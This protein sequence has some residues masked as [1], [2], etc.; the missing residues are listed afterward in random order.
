VAELGRV[1]VVAPWY[2][3]AGRPYWGTFVRESV[4]AL[5]PHADTITVVHA[6]VHDA[7]PAGESSL[8]EVDGVRVLRVPVQAAAAAPRSE[9]ALAVRAALDGVRDELLAADVVHAHVGLPTGWAVT[10][11]LA[12][13]V[14]VVVT[15]HASYLN[16]VFADPRTAAMYGDMVERAHA[17]TTVSAALSRALRRRY[18]HRAE[19]LT[20]VGNAVRPERWEPRTD[21]VR[22]LDRWLY[23]GNLLEAKGVLRLADAF[24]AWRAE[25][26]GATLVV[27]GDGPD[28]PRFEARVSE[29]GVADAVRLLGQVD[30]GGVAE[31]MRAADVLVHLSASETFGLTAVEAVMCGTPVVASETSGAAETLDVAQDLRMAWLVPPP[32]DPEAVLVAIRGQEERLAASRPQAARAD[33]VA[34][35]GT[36]AVGSHL[37]RLLAGGSD[38][39]RD[40]APLLVGVALHS[41]AVRHVTRTA[42]DAV[43]AGWRAV[44]VAD[45]ARDLVGLDERVLVVEVGDARAAMPNHRLERLLARAVPAGRLDR[46]GEKLVHAHVDPLALGR[47]VLHEGELD[48]TGVRLVVWGSP[49]GLPLAAR[50]L[51][52]YSRAEGAARLGHIEAVRRFAAL[53]DKA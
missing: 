46:V 43:R 53:A 22:R 42:S 48:L 34:R 12:G 37:A 3:T 52:D 14:R 27:A 38:A 19:A 13:S 21:R 2:P 47:R 10:D 39:P 29:L 16:Q 31:L 4:E 9:V 8:D 15:E 17:V 18:P 36:Q 23:V 51:R 1:V 45:R 5:R 6:D 20:T 11:L 32:V 24:A 30:P 50:I 28:R 33:L 44:V 26:P 40:V 41:S 25:R 7:E 35:Y 49:H